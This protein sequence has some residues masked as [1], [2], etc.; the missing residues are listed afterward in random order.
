MGLRR[1]GFDAGLTPLSSTIEKLNSLSWSLS[2]ARS[3]Y[4][5]RFLQ[6]SRSER[7]AQWWGRYNR[8]YCVSA[9]MDSEC[10]RSGIQRPLNAAQ[11]AREQDRLANSSTNSCLLTF[12]RSLLNNQGL[13]TWEGFD[14]NLGPVW[15]FRYG[16]VRAHISKILN[17]D[18]FS[19]F[20]QIFISWSSLRSVIVQWWRLFII[21]QVTAPDG[22]VHPI[23]LMMKRPKRNIPSY[24]FLKFLYKNFFFRFLKWGKYVARLYFQLCVTTSLASL[25]ACCHI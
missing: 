8:P 25:G 7:T 1:Y 13:F 15:A 18:F 21:R 16:T 4:I 11:R 20:F 10:C 12:I 14:N 22:S 5:S 3:L 2:R 19:F 6:S 17:S 9:A 23:G 24:L